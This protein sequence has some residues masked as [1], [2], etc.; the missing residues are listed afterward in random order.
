MTLNIVCEWWL[1][2]N[3]SSTTTSVVPLPPLGKAL[4]KTT[5]NIWC[6]G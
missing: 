6:N 4:K 3:T 5:S 2:N 1:I